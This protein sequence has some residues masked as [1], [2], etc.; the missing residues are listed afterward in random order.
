MSGGGAEA[1]PPGKSD[2]EEEEKV[3]CFVGGAGGDDVVFIL[4]LR[5]CVFIPDPN[6]AGKLYRCAENRMLSRLLQRCLVKLLLFLDLLG[7][8]KEVG[9][10]SRHDLA[11]GVIPQPGSGCR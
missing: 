8:C 5:S 2:T 9:G 10:E 3:V 7:V 6:R 1:R 11:G 4:I